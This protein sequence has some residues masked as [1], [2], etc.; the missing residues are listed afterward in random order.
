MSAWGFRAPGCCLLGLFCGP[1]HCPAL[2]RPFLTCLWL[3]ETREGD[4]SPLGLNSS[5]LHRTG[6]SRDQQDDL[7]PVPGR[8][9]TG[10]GLGTERK[11]QQPSPHYF[12]MK[13]SPTQRGA[14][15]DPGANWLLLVA[16]DMRVGSEDGSQ[17][18]QRGRRLSPHRG[19]PPNPV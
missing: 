16:G 5:V 8:G 9:G 7:C 10:K 6:W 11:S 15:R 13:K 19:L 3:W 12:L 14:D 2:Y 17:V 1:Q 4:L 18:W